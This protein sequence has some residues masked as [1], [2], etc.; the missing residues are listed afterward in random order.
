MAATAVSNA[1][2]DDVHAALDRLLAGPGAV[3]VVQG[4][5]GS[6]RSTALA[7]MAQRGRRSGAAVLP[8]PAGTEPGA[9]LLRLATQLAELI[10]A[11]D[12][13][14]LVSMLSAVAWLRTRLDSG[15][16]GSPLTVAHDLVTVFATLA[17]RSRIVL[18]FDDFDLVPPDVAAVL[19]LVAEGARAA[20]TVTVATAHGPDTAGAP[21]RKLLAIADGTVELRPLTDAETTGLLPSWTT[22]DGRTASDPGLVTALRTALGPLFGNPGTV[23][24][25]VADLRAR[26][27][28]AVVDEHVCLAG[29]GLPIVLP[30]SHPLSLRLGR[31]G[32]AARRLA[33][34][35]AV[36][37]ERDTPSID[38]LPGLAASAGLALPAAGH[39]LDELVRA[40]V[41]G[42]GREGA[43][44][45]AVP[46]LADRLRLEHGARWRQVLHR[47]ITR[48]SAVGTAEIARHL[49]ELPPSPANP[50]AAG[51]LLAEAAREETDL[52]TACRYRVTAL[53]LLS[54]ADERFPDVLRALLAASLAAGGYGVLADDLATVVLPRLGEARLTERLSATTLV[55][56]LAALA[57][58]QRLVELDVVRPLA[59]V[60]ADAGPLLDAVRQ[61]DR[62]TAASAVAGFARACGAEDDDLLS[63]GAG[64]L[65][66]ALPGD[67]SRL[68][69]A[70]PALAGVPPR[71]D[72]SE[73][74]D[75]LDS[76]SV[77]QVVL[78]GRYR[79]PSTGFTAGWHAVRQAYRDGEWDTALSLARRLEGERLW[80]E[81]PR[82]HRFASVFAAEIC[83]QRDEP[84]RAADWLRRL[85]FQTS[86]AAYVAWVRCRLRLSA[87]RHAEAVERGWQDYVACRERGVRAGLERLLARLLRAAREQADAPAVDRLLAELEGLAVRR[88]TAS[89]REASLVYGGLVRGDLESARAGVELARQS[90]DAFRGAE[91]CAA[92]GE[93]SPVPGPW[94]LEA[95]RTLKRLEAVATLASVE[96][97]LDRRRIT[98]PPDRADRA[99]LDPLERHIA[100]LVAS[101]RTNRQIAA[102]LRVSEKRVEARLTSLFE[103][104]GC[105]SRVELAAA[106]LQGRLGTA[107]AV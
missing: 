28:L 42:V 68:D 50:E 60:V 74:A 26:G 102:A 88:P 48:R 43:V 52:P 55:C 70:W 32:P 66:G 69:S 103:R 59:T 22:P 97:L 5:A 80:W 63:L 77:L 23:R 41:L 57:H 33:A 8:V 71:E 62:T 11:L 9:V 15:T 98:V 1:G 86:A 24:A 87:G 100:G 21:V 35:L 82:R 89:V 105:Q 104:T 12:R 84:D 29:T 106:W 20:G 13:M 34:V 61:G 18:Q 17:P 53:R 14:E 92:F 16:G 96:D 81:P 90:G 25:T 19:T 93:L 37:G 2:P 40:G 39:G 78:P 38:A 51:V 54:P 64:I 73:A 45:F 44:E 101:G 91:A 46:A 75:V 27:R 10:T 107:A 58:E 6:G 49:A 79:P 56:W 95:H 67:G 36:L 47:G 85:P 72:V 83:A 99:G 3:W 7:A 76:V 4:P 94:L 31:L 65:L 30:A